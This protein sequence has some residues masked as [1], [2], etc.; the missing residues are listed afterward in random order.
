MA[1]QKNLMVAA[2]AGLGVAGYLLWNIFSEKSHSAS[3][4][5]E[6]KAKDGVITAKDDQIASKDADLRT[7]QSQVQKLKG[8]LGSA[9]K[10]N[11]LLTKQVQT[12]KLEAEWARW[13]TNNNFV[14]DQDE[15][16]G[17]VTKLVTDWLDDNTDTTQSV[18]FMFGLDGSDEAIALLKERIA[19][20][21]PSAVK[22]F[23]TTL[24]KDGNGNVDKLEFIKC[25]T[26]W[27]DAQ[28]QEVLNATNARG[29]TLIKKVK[30]YIKMYNR[31]LRQ[32]Q[33][34]Q[35][36]LGRD[37]L[38]QE[39][40]AADK[41]GNYF[42][43]IDEVRVLVKSKLET[44]IK[45]KKSSS[46][47]G[48]GYLFGEVHE[49]TEA[50][51]KE[52]LAQIEANFDES[53]DAFMAEVDTN[54]DGKIDKVEFFDSFSHWLKTTLE[55]QVGDKAEPYFIKLGYLRDDG[56][57]T[58]TVMQKLEHHHAQMIRKVANVTRDIQ[59]LRTK[60]RNP[61][62]EEVW[63]K[64]DKDNNGV[65]D[66]GEVQRLV[67]ALLTEQSIKL[68]LSDF[69][70]ETDTKTSMALSNQIGSHLEECTLSFLKHVDN[71]SDGKIDKVEFFSA[72][73]AWAD[74]QLA[75]IAKANMTAPAD[76]EVP[77]TK[78]VKA[79]Q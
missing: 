62:L 33:D 44:A 11:A 40:A 8:Q 24:D 28:M 60:L 20:N 70:E 18:G 7:A 74:S 12:S 27:S 39:W 45:S 58:N 65:L 29:V 71:N 57:I 63:S 47:M 19:V 35:R 52:V 43:D 41:D 78:E 9:L 66:R 51:A 10:Q 37:Q 48:L 59:R 25:F 79:K 21:V 26:H 64:H 50:E 30:Q 13:D 14:L 46:S 23:V 77:A 56:E 16:E 53:L 17:L 49:E 4:A 3:L 36:A 2:G 69:D 42:L 1:E 68:F 75:A 31:R 32:L 73:P 38:E 15:V 67:S 5:G 72:F 22:S 6:L 55:K 54:K 76:R 34:L 61:R